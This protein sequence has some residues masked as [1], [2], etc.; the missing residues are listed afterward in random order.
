M[1]KHDAG[2]SLVYTSIAKEISMCREALIA[3]HLH[4]IFYMIQR[5]KT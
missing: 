5:D 1:K 2:K 4:C 3:L